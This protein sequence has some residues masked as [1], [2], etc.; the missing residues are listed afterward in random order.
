M[1]LAFP[2]ATRPLR[3]D[4]GGQ[5]NLHEISDRLDDL[6]VGVEHASVSEPADVGEGG[7]ALNANTR[8]SLMRR[9]AGETVPDAIPGPMLG[10]G[11]PATAPAATAPQNSGSGM[12]SLTPTRCLLLTNMFDPAEETEP[13]WDED[14]KEDVADEVSK[15]GQ[16]ETIQID[17][18]EDQLYVHWLS[19]SAEKRCIVL[20]QNSKGWV[21]IKFAT[22]QACAGAQAALNGRWFAARKIVAEFQ[23]ELLFN[24]KLGTS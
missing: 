21:F 1:A 2:V 9:L 20:A 7:V 6:D 24:A 10:N 5:F 13:Q 22:E 23:N 12:T 8:H 16:I 3:E 19:M 4:A 15:Y 18:V 14:I 11:I 17:K